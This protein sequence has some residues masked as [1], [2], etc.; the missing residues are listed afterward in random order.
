MANEQYAFLRRPELPTTSVLQAA[1][2]ND[3]D[4][5]LKIDPETNLT[6]DAGFVPCVICNVE[7]GV[8]IYFDDSAETIKRFGDMVADRDCCLVFRWGGDFAE[9]ACAVVLSYILAKYFDAVISYEGAPPQENLETLRR[10]AITIHQ[11]ANL[12]LS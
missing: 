12:N 3:P 8:E 11:H 10:E 2:D 9:C 5:S 1:I 7:S 6:E 4:F